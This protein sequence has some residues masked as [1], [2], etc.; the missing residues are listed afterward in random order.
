MI[1]KITCCNNAT[2]YVAWRQ[3]NLN[4]GHWILRN[5]SNIN[6]ITFCPFCGATLPPTGW[7]ETDLI[8]DLV[9]D[10][11][12]VIANTEENKYHDSVG[13]DFA[14]ETL[15]ELYNA[16]NQGNRMFTIALQTARY[17]KRENGHQTKAKNRGW[18]E[19]KEWLKLYEVPYDSVYMGKAAGDLYIDDKG[20]RVESSK[21]VSDW[22][23]N[24][25]PAL[26][27]VIAK[28]QGTYQ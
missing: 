4:D 17:M 23:N 13:F 21:G 26:Q 24:F 20:C 10:I 16:Q 27:K 28:K 11:D 7:I 25:E 8:I 18:K 2:Q 6:Q 9:F 14:I 15:H 22:K 5:D 19:L 12:G 3:V 1:P